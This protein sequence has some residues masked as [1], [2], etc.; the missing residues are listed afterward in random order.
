MSVGVFNDSSTHNLKN[1]VSWEI[2]SN[3]RHVEAAPA[4]LAVA[5]ER[6]DTR[7]DLN[8][9]APPIGPN[10]SKKSFHIPSSVIQR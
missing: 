3:P 4:R 8:F 5:M 6:M 7:A 10:K 9:H 2:D 1:V